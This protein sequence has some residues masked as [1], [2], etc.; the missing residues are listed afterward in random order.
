MAD[1]LLV[2]RVSFKIQ[3]EA[4]TIYDLAHQFIDT[5]HV[6]DHLFRLVPGEHGRDA[7]GFGGTD[8]DQSLVVQLDVENMA[9]KKRMALRAWFCVEAATFRSVAR[10]TRNAR[11]SAAP[12]VSGCCLL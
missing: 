2:L 4:A 6:R 9:V 8:W 7:F 1:I 10:W 12:I 5:I 3:A 11:I